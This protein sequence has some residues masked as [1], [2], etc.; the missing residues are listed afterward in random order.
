QNA[1]TFVNNNTGTSVSS[2]PL[3]TIASAS[4]STSVYNLG[5]GSLTLT[6]GQT[7]VGYAGNGAFN[8]SGGLFTI[9][10]TSSSAQPALYIARSAGSTGAYNLSSG[11]LA[12]TN[13]YVMVGY[14]GNGV[15]NQSSGNITLTSSIGA[16]GSFELGELA[17]GTGIYNLSGGSL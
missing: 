15:F 3:L 5:S 4:T 11:S 16:G 14:Q 12:I 1:G 9:N 7:Y 17:G 6:K 8:Q 10:F 13:G 2:T